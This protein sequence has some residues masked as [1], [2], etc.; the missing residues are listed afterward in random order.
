[1]VDCGGGGGGGGQNPSL[2]VEGGEA[3]QA[4]RA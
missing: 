3:E 4:A 1:V 2:R